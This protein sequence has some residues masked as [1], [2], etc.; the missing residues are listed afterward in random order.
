MFVSMCVLYHAV[1]CIS[2]EILH[3]T[4]ANSGGASS[5]YTK[6]LVGFNVHFGTRF[7]YIFSCSPLTNI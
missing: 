7:S 6:I 4:F 3:C 1:M 2:V 5:S